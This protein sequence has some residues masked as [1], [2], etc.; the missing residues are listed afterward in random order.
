MQY[1][2]TASKLFLLLILRQN[3]EGYA[4]ISPR[5]RAGLASDVVF[6]ERSTLLTFD[7]ATAHRPTPDSV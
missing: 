2:C 6:R 5:D 1:L 7:Q 3:N 4:P